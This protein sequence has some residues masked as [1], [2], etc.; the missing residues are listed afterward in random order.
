MQGV[1]NVKNSVFIGKQVKI[2]GWIEKLSDEKE[3][4]SIII[5][6]DQGDFIECISNK[7]IEKITEGSS[8]EVTGILQ[9]DAKHGKTN[10]KI[11]DSNIGV[12][13]IADS[14]ISKILSSD[15]L[16]RKY[17]HILLR[18]K[19]MIETAKIRAS[20]QKYIREWFNENQWWEVNCPVIV[21]APIQTELSF[22]INYFD[23]E[24]FV[25]HNTQ[26][27]IETM[28]FSLGKVWTINPSFRSEKAETNRHLSEF[29]LLQTEQLWADLEDVLTI[30]ENLVTYVVENIL[31]DRKES[32]GILKSNVN[33]LQSIRPPFDKL[34]YSDAINMLR[35]K[36]FMVEENGNKRIIEWGDDIG[37]AGEWELTYNRN[38][39]LFL[40]HYPMSV[41]PFY[42]KHHGKHNEQSLSVDLLAPRGFGE[43]TSGGLREDDITLIRKELRR[44]NLADNVY[45]WY[46]DL[47]KY[48]WVPH[49]GFGLGIDRLIR[50]VT[51][52]ENI[53]DVVMFP[54]TASQLEP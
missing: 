49:G 18:T 53:K 43:I 36:D 20:T 2:R 45:E 13:S 33:Y 24:A 35:S 38:T 32:L 37:N 46:I 3:L 9:K 21:N 51:N 6:D 34:K 26:L 19:K 25:S 48:G 54:R 1:K 8:I 4:K 30:Q 10:Y 39:P 15:Q 5:R 42:I 16:T 44:R 52:T 7:K 12:F 31:K 17:R 28:A 29:L 50:W 22:K 14:N 40:T 11:L 23:K 27:Y 47:R 41:R